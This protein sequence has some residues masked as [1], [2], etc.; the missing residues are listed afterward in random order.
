MSEKNCIVCTQT[1]FFI[2]KQKA[3]DDFQIVYQ[4]IFASFAPDVRDLY[5][6]TVRRIHRKY[7]RRGRDIYPP[8]TRRRQRAHVVSPILSAGATTTTAS[9]S[10]RM[11]P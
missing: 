5:R 4:I 1:A 2:E 8:I 9:F 10:S 7:E 11:A 3:L 6:S